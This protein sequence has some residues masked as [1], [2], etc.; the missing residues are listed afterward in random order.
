MFSHTNSKG[1]MYYL[2]SKVVRLRGGRMQTIY[3]FSKDSSDSIDLPQ[4][5]EVIESKRTGLPLLKKV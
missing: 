4:G 3:Y 2:H 1:Q 5:F